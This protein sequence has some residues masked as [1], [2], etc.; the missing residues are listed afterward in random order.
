MVLSKLGLGLQTSAEAGKL[1]HITIEE[2]IQITALMFTRKTFLLFLSTIST[3]IHHFQCWKI[4]NCQKETKFDAFRPTNKPGNNSL[5][6]NNIN[7]TATTNSYRHKLQTKVRIFVDSQ[8]RQIGNELHK[9]TNL[10]ITSFVKTNATFEHATAG[11]SMERA[12][13]GT[14]DLVVFIAG[15]NDVARNETQHLRTSLRRRLQEMRG[16]NVMVFSVPRQYDLASWSCVN[17]EVD[18]ANV[19]ISKVCKYFRNVTYVDLSNFGRRF[20]TNHGL[21]LNMLGKKLVT[22]KILELVSSIDLT[23]R[24]KC[25]LFL[26]RV[27]F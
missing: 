3:N 21:H 19:E 27:L 7:V 11:S 10:N 20:H 1:C 24:K 17:M 26:L 14:N 13:L 15:R 25:I 16:T 8:G 2:G 5:S 12:A 23:K 6:T 18:R 9:K 22:Y 4:R